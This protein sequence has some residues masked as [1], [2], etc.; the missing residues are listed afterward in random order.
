MKRLMSAW[1][2]PF[3]KGSPILEFRQGA[4]VQIAGQAGA[5]YQGSAANGPGGRRQ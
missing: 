5:F 1:K 3:T 2:R 4:A